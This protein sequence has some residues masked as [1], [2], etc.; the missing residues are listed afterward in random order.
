MNRFIKIFAITTFFTWPILGFYLSILYHPAFGI[1]A[2]FIGAA[3][4][5]LTIAHVLDDFLLLKESKSRRGNEKI[6]PVQNAEIVCNGTLP[7]THEHCVN[8]LQSINARITKSDIKEGIVYA[9]TKM[10]WES[11]GEKI[12]ISLSAPGTDVTII[13][14]QSA[15]IVP[16]TKTDYGKGKRN[17]EQLVQYLEPYRKNQ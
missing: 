5:G 3:I 8:A 13:S 15:P 6:L 7:A 2:G 10:T 4:A 14:I 11:F 16:T 17:I 9:R 12:I 1:A